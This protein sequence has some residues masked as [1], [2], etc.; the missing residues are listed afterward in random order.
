MKQKWNQ[1]ATVEESSSISAA[2]L[3]VIDVYSK[4]A[5]VDC[6]QKC[7]MSLIIMVIPK[8]YI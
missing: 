4:L 8:D 2:I 3:D 1:V 6:I 5:L 7:L